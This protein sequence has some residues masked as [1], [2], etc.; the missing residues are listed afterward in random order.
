LVQQILVEYCQK[1]GIHIT[2]FSPLGSSSYIPLGMDQGHKA[3]LLEEPVIK[4]IAAKYKRSTAQVALRWNVQRN[5][6][7]IPKTSQL[8][9]LKEN[10]EIFDFKLTEEEMKQISALNR[11]TRY[12]D[13]GEFCKGMGGS[14]PIYA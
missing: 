7:V 9:R 2:G 1:I 11:N 3:G 6:I 10:L 5:V 12:N 8:V 4:E 14:Y 13:P